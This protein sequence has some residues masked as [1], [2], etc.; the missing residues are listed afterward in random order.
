MS[1]LQS[2]FQ[3]GSQSNFP[4]LPDTFKPELLRRMTHTEFLLVAAQYGIRQ[5][6]ERLNYTELVN[7][8]D[9]QTQDQ[10]KDQNDG[11]TGTNCAQ[12]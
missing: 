5:V 4:L 1:N 8:L 2:N 9:S 3:S 6:A 12:E 11:N 7:A 10:T